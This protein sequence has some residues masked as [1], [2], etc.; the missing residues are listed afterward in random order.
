MKLF[1]V[2][3]VLM[4][5]LAVAGIGF[6]YGFAAVQV[7]NAYSIDQTASTTDFSNFNVAS[8][9]GQ[10]AAPFQ[11]FVASVQSDTVGV[12]IIQSTTLPFID[13]DAT[14]AAQNYLAQVSSQISSRISNWFSGWGTWIQEKA[15]WFD[16]QI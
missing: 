1:N 6:R 11:N 14:A 16:M 8:G 12:P 4:F 7:A 15:A 5:V 3:K 10:L 2:H 9:F 13:G